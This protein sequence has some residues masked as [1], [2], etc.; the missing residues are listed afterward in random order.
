LRYGDPVKISD[1]VQLRAD[2]MNDAVGIALDLLIPWQS[3]D[4]RYQRVKR[5]SE[6]VPIFKETKK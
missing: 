6:A 3:N 4:N 2:G 1:Y 5:A